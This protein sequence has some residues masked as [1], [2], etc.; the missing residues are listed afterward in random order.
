MKSLYSSCTTCTELSN[1]CFNIQTE[2]SILKSH[3]LEIKSEPKINQYRKLTL[4]VKDRKLT[5]G[6]ED[7]TDHKMF[8]LYSLVMFVKNR[9]PI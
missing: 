2:K 9:L 1:S 5:L 7:S 3:L 8:L 4:D 6:V